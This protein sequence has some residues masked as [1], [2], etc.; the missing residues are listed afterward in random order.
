MSAEVSSLPLALSEVEREIA[1]V[2]AE[3][4]RI[5]A[6]VANLAVKKRSLLKTLSGLKELL[7]QAEPEPL[8]ADSGS[9]N[10][11]ELAS[12]VSH[13]SR[14]AFRGMGPAAAA[15]KYLRDVGQ[16][17]THA[18]V[19]DALLRGNVKSKAK[20]PSDSFRTAMQ[21]R[22]DWFVWKK[23]LG[24]F[25]YWELVEWQCA[26]EEPKAN[27]TVRPLVPKALSLVGQ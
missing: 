25:G 19:V 15:R 3:A 20:Y 7:G 4:E 16:R 26:D 6:E 24:Q 12:T 10:E 17:Q 9:F 2:D 22:T 23:E 1:T 5:T 27:D 21:R 14:N 11:V 18:E 13:V 8:P